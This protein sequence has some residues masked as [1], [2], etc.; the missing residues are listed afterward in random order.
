ME[1]PVE[2]VQETALRRRI[3]HR[4][5]RHDFGARLYLDPYRS[6]RRQ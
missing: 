5:V 2:P 4:N 6:G 3:L 1:K